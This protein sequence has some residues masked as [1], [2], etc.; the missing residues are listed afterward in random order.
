MKFMMKQRLSNMYINYQK[1]PSK[2]F[3]LNRDPSHFSKLIQKNAGKFL[4]LAKHIQKIKNFKKTKY[5]IEKLKIENLLF[6][7]YPHHNLLQ[8]KIFS[9]TISL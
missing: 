1:F 4:S 8:S 2:F 6:G 9:F 5:K 7:F 3:H